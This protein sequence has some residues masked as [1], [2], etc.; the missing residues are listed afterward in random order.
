MSR[1]RRAP[2]RIPLPASVYP[3]I[4]EVGA[5][6][7][8]PRRSSHYWHSRDPMV[9]PIRPSRRV[10][11]AASAATPALGEKPVCEGPSSLWASFGWRRQSTGL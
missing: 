5:R 2:A 8:R 6:H 3:C 1:S 7:H 4:P 11:I 9:K 10:L